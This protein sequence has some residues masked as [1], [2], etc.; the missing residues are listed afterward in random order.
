MSKLY[1]ACATSSRS[2]SAITLD[3]TRHCPLPEKR[4]G[5]GASRARWGSAART[6]REFV[7]TV[8]A[9]A[10]AGASLIYLSCLVLPLG[11]ERRHGPR[12]TY[13]LELATQP[14]TPRHHRAV[15]LALHPLQVGPCGGGGRAR[16][17]GRRQHGARRA[18]HGR[19]GSRRAR[20]E[21]RWNLCVAETD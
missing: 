6:S 18:S 11:A 5:E 17:V 15:S 20:C 19:G 4:P 21:S 2:A 12:P 10:C 7:V 3:R 1:C 14:P 8:C 16:R 13:S 9:R